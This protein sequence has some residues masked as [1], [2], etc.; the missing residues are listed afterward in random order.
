M[1]MK[2]V[3][4]VVGLLIFVGTVVGCSSPDAADAVKTPTAN[5]NAA[6]KARMRGVGAPGGA[7]K[8]SAE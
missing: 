3:L 7:Q 8:P 5:P 2:H 4:V 6:E 1:K